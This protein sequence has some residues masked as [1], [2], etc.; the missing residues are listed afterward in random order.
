MR[1]LSWLH[2]YHFSLLLCVSAQKSMIYTH[3]SKDFNKVALFKDDQYASAQ[4]IFNKVKETAA[5]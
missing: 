4:I 3:D 5:T 1:K 2:F